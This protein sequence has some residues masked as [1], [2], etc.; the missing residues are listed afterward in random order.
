MEVKHTL[1]GRFVLLFKAVAY[2]PNVGG[3]VTVRVGDRRRTL[4]L[5]GS[6]STGEEFAVEFDRAERSNVAEV[7]VPYPSCPTGDGRAIDIGFYSLR[8]GPVREPHMPP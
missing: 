3:D 6:V 7:V 1:G 5:P 4:R 8:S 2:G